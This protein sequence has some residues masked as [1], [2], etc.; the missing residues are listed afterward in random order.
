MVQ[1]APGRQQQV[2]CAFGHASC[3][4]SDRGLTT[5]CPRAGFCLNSVGLR[6]GLPTIV[7]PFFG[8]Q[9]FWG[10]RIT[11]VTPPALCVVAPRMHVA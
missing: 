10:E 3:T 9:F 5:V 6:A 1:V 7:K 8:D 11:S 2:R 4:C